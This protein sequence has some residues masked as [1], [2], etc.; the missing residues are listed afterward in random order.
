M[1]LPA[2]RPPP[3]KPDD[4]TVP[5][6]PELASLKVRLS[7]G[8]VDPDVVEDVL[9]ALKGAGAAE[10]ARIIGALTAPGGLRV[11]LDEDPVEPYKT[12]DLA[13]PEDDHEL[14]G[15]YQAGLHLRPRT[16]DRQRSPEPPTGFVPA[17]DGSVLKRSTLGRGTP[18]QFS[19]SGKGRGQ[20]PLE[21]HFVAAIE[22]LRTWL[23]LI[24]RRAV[25]AGTRR[26]LAA[27]YRAFFDREI[28]SPSEIWGGV[29]VDELSRAKLQRVQMAIQAT[30]KG[31]QVNPHAAWARASDISF[32]DDVATITIGGNEEPLVIPRDRV[33]AGPRIAKA[34]AQQRRDWSI[35]PLEPG[36]VRALIAT[37]RPRY[38]LL[39]AS[40]SGRSDKLTALGPGDGWEE[41]VAEDDVRWAWGVD[42]TS[43]VVVAEEDSE[44]TWAVRMSSAEYERFTEV[45][46]AALL[47]S[48]N[49]RLPA[50]IHLPEHL[51]NVQIIEWLAE[52]FS[53]AS[54][55][56]P[57]GTM[58]AKTLVAVAADPAELADRIRKDALR[59]REPETR[60]RLARLAATLDPVKNK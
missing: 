57:T 30:R 35:G 7:E 29:L 9:G 42:S 19:P 32:T 41:Q 47:R 15:A 25:G 48:V 24:E 22:E 3:Q 5:L 18:R 54:G 40:R 34:T 23:K 21:P 6:D 50:G 49:R 17:P 12:H 39:N 53:L 10:R 44:Q 26:R 55:K 52:K 43:W 38:Y 51:S 28:P 13:T 4:E 59:R 20:R 33:V 60:A 2:S 8:N 58:K 31:A 56:G 27:A 37:W 14:A 45:T 16:A 1:T 36:T 46:P 11:L